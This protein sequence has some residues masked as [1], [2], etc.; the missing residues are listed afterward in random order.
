MKALI[1]CIIVGAALLGWAYHMAVWDFSSPYALHNAVHAGKI[2]QGQHQEEVRAILGSHWRVNKNYLPNIYAGSLE[3][4]C[5]W[6]ECIYFHRAAT[7]Y[8]VH[9]INYWTRQGRFPP[10]DMTGI[11]PMR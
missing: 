9:W 11:D 8:V 4:W 6:G 7:P 1:G 10:E 2:R 3:E 5:R